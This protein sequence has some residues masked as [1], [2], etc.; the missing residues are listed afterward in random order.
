VNASYADLRDKVAVV[1]GGSAGIGAATA[2]LLAADGTKVAVAAR[3]EGP[4][5]ELV[6]EIR[7]A[8][9]S[10]VG[11]HADASTEAALA[12]IR[13]AVLDRYGGV[14]LLLAFVGGGAAQI[15]VEDI[16][17]A[18]WS[19]VVERNLTS[20]FLAVRT[21]VPVLA[22]RRSPAIVTM[23][24]AAGQQVDTPLCAAY[25]AAKAGVAHLTRHIA[26]ELGPRGIRANCIAPSTTLSP[27]V[28]ESLKGKPGLAE[29]VLDIT[30]LGR[31][32]EPVDVARAA[33]YLCSEA[34]GWLTGA[35]IDV[36][37]GRV[38]R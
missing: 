32:G 8:G 33:V 17:E 22:G 5:T 13:A 37:G 18:T 27:R 28:S 29:K 16:E 35:T 11:L 38:M 20:T 2:R 12:E 3:R 15:A 23:G 25:A 19:S 14:D 31:L 10:A 1:L 21:F 6:D 26:V 24:S 34:S 9:G 36:G 7:E 30:P 4:L